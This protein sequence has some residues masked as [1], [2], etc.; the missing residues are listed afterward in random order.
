MRLHIIK[1]K[2]QKWVAGFSLIELMVVVAIIGVLASIAV[3]AYDGYMVR[4]RTAHMVEIALA[5][6]RAISETRNI[7]GYFPTTTSAVTVGSVYTAP[8]DPYVVTPL[9]FPTTASCSSTYSFNIVGQG[10]N[11]GNQPTMR[12]TATWTPAS[13][14][15]APALTW[16]CNIYY[17]TAVSAAYAPADCTMNTGAAPAV[18]C[19]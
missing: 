18:S 2:L 11:A 1:N 16:T 17:T 7:Q 14:S 12:M 8:T 3:P 6:K 15:A 5:A 4:A 10:I 13:A 19:T 9:T